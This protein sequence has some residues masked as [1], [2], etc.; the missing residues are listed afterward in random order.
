VDATRCA[1]FLQLARKAFMVSDA[2]GELSAQSALPPSVHN[3][4]V[5]LVAISP[6]GR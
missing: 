3:K 5:E 4:Q 1:A 6:L 2:E